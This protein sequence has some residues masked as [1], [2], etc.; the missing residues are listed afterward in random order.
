MKAR[1][2][3]IKEILSCPQKRLDPQHYLPEHK[4]DECGGAPSTP[5]KLKDLPTTYVMGRRG[6]DFE[7]VRGWVVG[8][9]PCTLEG[10]RGRRYGTR[11]PDGSLTWPCGKGMEWDHKEDA[12]RII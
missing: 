2:V 8:M 7:N 6:T 9:K 4:T 1:M 12:W 10:C 5:R 11:W 3:S